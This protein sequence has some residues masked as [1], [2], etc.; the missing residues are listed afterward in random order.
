MDFAKYSIFMQQDAETGLKSGALGLTRASYASDLYE[1][2]KI[3]SKRPA[4][5]NEAKLTTTKQSSLR[6]PSDTLS[7]QSLDHG[8]AYKLSEKILN[9]LVN[10]TKNF[11][12]GYLRALSQLSE[13]SEAINGITGQLGGLQSGQNNSD[14]GLY[15]TT[16]EI[17]CSAFREVRVTLRA[18]LERILARV[19]QAPSPGEAE[20]AKKLVSGLGKEDDHFMTFEPSAA[21][22]QGDHSTKDSRHIHLCSLETVKPVK[23]VKKGVVE[24][25]QKIWIEDENY[26]TKD[27]HSSHRDPRPEPKAIKPST[28][29]KNHQ[30][31]QKNSQKNFKKNSKISRIEAERESK[32]T[33]TDSFSRIKSQ[34]AD[35][36]H[37]RETQTL[38]EQQE[39][40]EQQ[41]T[42]QNV[43]NSQNDQK[44]IKKVNSEQSIQMK[45]MD[46]PFKKDESMSSIKLK[47]SPK[48]DPSD[49]SDP[50]SEL[51]EAK[52]DQEG[53]ES[54]LGPYR[55]SEPQVSSFMDKTG[56]EALDAM[57]EV[58]YTKLRT[59]GGKKMSN[60]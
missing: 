58:D 27:L 38:E 7:D 48:E 50:L 24:S 9:D 32:N 5:P 23:N 60:F 13:Q 21:E 19:R 46:I 35:L 43:Q 2:K 29:P 8:L 55:N 28:S 36:T 52:E 17:L 39:P 53:P 54:G 18:N 20:D 14:L 15:S 33:Q 3:T 30:K 42:A 45:S 41:K 31:S 44:S 47:S 49:L 57:F 10:Y 59:K 22:N 34:K 11:K 6:S 16:S 37:H 1:T 26:K 51:K 40:K 25:D 12:K 56:K 4:N